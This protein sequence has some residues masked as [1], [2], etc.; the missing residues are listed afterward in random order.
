[1][2]ILTIR[3]VAI[4]YNDVCDVIDSSEVNGPPVHVGSTTSSNLIA[5]SCQEK[6][7]ILHVY[8]PS[9]HPKRIYH[10]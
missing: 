2:E 3:I 10:M 5:T 1:M 8:K 4:S 9:N 7:T 6:G